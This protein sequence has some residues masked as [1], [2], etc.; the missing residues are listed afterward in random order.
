MATMPSLPLMIRWFG[1]RNF[2][3]SI[4]FVITLLR[5]P[6]R[7]SFPRSSRLYLHVKKGTLLDGYFRDIAID[8]AGVQEVII[9]TEDEVIVLPHTTSPRYVLF[10]LQSDRG[11]RRLFQGRCGKR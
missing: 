4:P 8:G 2:T 1:I 10:H 9:W 7:V 3:F 6:T 5:G 11:V